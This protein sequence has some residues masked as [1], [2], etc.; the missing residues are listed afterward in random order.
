MIRK[1]CLYYPPLVK[2]GMFPLIT[3][4]RQFK[5]SASRE[6]RIYPLVMASLATM[7]DAAGYDVLFLDGINRRISL[8]N[9]EKIL[10]DF[11]PEFMVIETKAP[12]FTAHQ[13]YIRELASRINCRFAICGDHI[14]CAGAKSLSAGSPFSW[15]VGGGYYDFIIKNLVDWLNGKINHPPPGVFYKNS[16]QNIIYSQDPE[17]G[18][19]NLDEAP[20]I[21]RDLTRWSD[22]GEAY[23]YR[24]A[25][26]ILS[27]RGCGGAN[28]NH[29]DYTSSMPG[30]C[31]FCIWQHALWR[32]KAVLRSPESTADEIEILVKKYRV[33][34]IFDDNESGGIWNELWLENF[35]RSLE[36]RRLTGKFYFS[37]NA[38]A[39]SLTPGRIRLLQKI[40]C[41]LLKVGVES[42]NDST[43]ACIKKDENFRAISD[44][45]KNAKDAGI[46]VLMTTMVGYPWESSAEMQHTHHE[47]KKLLLY[48]THFGDSLQSSIFTPYPGSPVYDQ[49]LAENKIDFSLPLSAYDMDHKVLLSEIDTGRACHEMWKLHLHPLFLLR[50]LFAMRHADDFLLALR[51]IKSLLGHLGDYRIENDRGN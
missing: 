22:Y 33:R 19:F 11:S 8:E 7:L 29:Q 2:N 40:G 14:S 17:S 3:Q 34:E 50:S 45:I 32:R 12:L 47:V 43:L 26:Y 4:N 27:G 41:R 51:G 35:Y 49:S 30:R 44:G 42:A 20:L 6:I 18:A 31:T 25:A 36:K 46:A 48:K 15:A 1:I 23:L 9:C 24:P 38:R 39:D 16:D 13:D 5:F 21:D 10:A 28:T 37:S